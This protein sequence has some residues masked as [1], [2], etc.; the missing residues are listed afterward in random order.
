MDPLDVEELILQTVHLHFQV[1][2][3]LS[4]VIQDLPQTADVGVHRLTHGQLVIVP[5]THR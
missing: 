5:E 3:D 4:Q 2:P 1:R